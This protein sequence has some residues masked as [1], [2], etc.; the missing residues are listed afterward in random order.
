MG[1]GEA[2]MSCGPEDIKSGFARLELEKSAFHNIYASVLAKKPTRKCGR[3]QE[4]SSKNSVPSQ[5]ICSIKV[6]LFVYLRF[7]LNMFIRLPLIAS[8]ENLEEKL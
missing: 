5:I 7:R 3:L 6:F 4:V 8:R 1:D 2:G